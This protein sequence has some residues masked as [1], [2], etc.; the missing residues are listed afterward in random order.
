MNPGSQSYPDDLARD[1]S[2]EIA[3]NPHAT[4]RR[5]WVA[6]K[7]RLSRWAVRNGYPL[8]VIR[9]GAR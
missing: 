5:G 7:A 1:D 6:M 3:G 2:P 8:G 9:V 4:A